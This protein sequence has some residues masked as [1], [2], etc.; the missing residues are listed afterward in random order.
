MFLKK[1]FIALFLSVFLIVSSVTGGYKEAYA[2]PV[3]IPLVVVL[4]LLVGS[5][6]VG[7]GVDLQIDDWTSLTKDLSVSM[8]N[9]DTAVHNWMADIF[10][11]AIDGQGKTMLSALT[12]GTAITAINLWDYSIPIGAAAIATTVIIKNAVVDF[13]C[14]KFGYRELVSG[15]VDYTVDAIYGTMQN[16]G[17]DVNKMSNVDYTFLDY[18]Y[19]LML[20]YDSSSMSIVVTNKLPSVR[21]YSVGSS[22]YGIECYMEDSHFYSVISNEIYESSYPLQTFSLGYRDTGL[23]KLNK[24]HFGY[25]VLNNW[26]FDWVN[27]ATGVTYSFPAQGEKYYI[28]ATDI[29]LASDDDLDVIPITS[30]LATNVADINIDNVGDIKSTDQL[31]SISADAIVDTKPR[32]ITDIWN[33]VKAL[34]AEIGVAVNGVLEKAF[35]PSQAAVDN[36]VTTA[37]EKVESGTSI[38]TYPFE[39]VVAFTDGFNDLGVQ[40]C[41]LVIPKIEFKDYTLYPGYSFNFTQY[42]AQSH[43][44]TIYTY[45]IYF[46]NFVLSISVLNL[47]LRK[48]DEFMT[49][50]MS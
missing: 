11:W 41:I 18:K 22:S 27:T 40:D 12:A 32:T 28:K 34:P 14:N 38:F 10:S 15:G 42:V 36:F 33:R 30:G 25:M 5:V 23:Y 1:R 29:D 39:V 48:W 9:G 16:Y 50:G 45:Y 31:V 3:A 6:A 46:V 43:F 49:G 24:N 37:Q 26:A 35:V 4:M 20:R 44:A 47:A 7:A 8:Y 13:I 19:I 17:F 2:L 21:Y